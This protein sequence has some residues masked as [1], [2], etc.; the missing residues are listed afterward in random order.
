LSYH[1]KP[2]HR[3]GNVKR[4]HHLLQGIEGCLVEVARHP[5]I[6]SIIPGRIKSAVRGSQVE[7]NY[8]YRT[9]SGLKFLA[10]SSGGVQEI[11]I[12]TSKPDTIIEFVENMF[13]T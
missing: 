9:T 2:K 5:D 13:K 3:K 11:F 10:K 1:R 12:V 6:I 7:L 4:E 8:K